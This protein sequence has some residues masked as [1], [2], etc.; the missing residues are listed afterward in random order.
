[1]TYQQLKAA[2]MPLQNLDA[3]T[4]AP[5]TAG[6]G[7]TRKVFSVQAN[8]IAGGLILAVC[9][10]HNFCDA[11]GAARIVAR[12][13]EHCD[14]SATVPKLNCESLGSGMPEIFNRDAINAKYDHKRLKQDPNL[15][16]LNCL[17]HRDPSKDHVPFEW[18]IVLPSLMPLQDPPVNS[19]M[20]TFTSQALA[21]LKAFA[22]PN[23][24]DSCITYPDPDTCYHINESVDQLEDMSFADGEAYNAKLIAI[25]QADVLP[26]RSKPEEVILYDL[27][28]SMRVHDREL[29]DEV[30]EPTFTFMRSQT[31]R[32]RLT[33]KELG[34][35]LI[36]RER[37]VGKAYVLRLA[38]ITAPLTSTAFSPL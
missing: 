38:Y 28:E 8:F 30:L 20:F 12:F 27:W 23:E 9:F 34:N 13:S 1:M 32:V 29:A 31:D 4:F 5:L 6:I 14:G 3:H 35:Y 7:E 36:Y 17:D 37:D 19:F 10:H 24:G 21:E 25:S 18:P 33:I 2:G 15:W 11:Y 22:K 16:Q 26:D